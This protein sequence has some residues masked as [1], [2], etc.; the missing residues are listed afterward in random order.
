MEGSKWAEIKAMEGNIQDRAGGQD[1][2][3]EAWQ[4]AP[5]M[6]LGQVTCLSWQVSPASPSV[7]Y[8]WMKGGRWAGIC[9]KTAYS[10]LSTCD[11]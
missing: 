6:Q 11:M 2:W 7:A 1:W 3:V 10:P 5:G 8:S 4:C 9:A